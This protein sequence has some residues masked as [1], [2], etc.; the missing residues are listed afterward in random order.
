MSQVVR[1][2]AGLSD[3]ILCLKDPLTGLCSL[4]HLDMFKAI[5]ELEVKGTVR[6]I[7]ENEPP[8]VTD[9]VKVRTPFPPS[10]Y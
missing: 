5:K 9:K 6:I 8:P 3:A 7:K 1:G 10:A 4:N 2:V